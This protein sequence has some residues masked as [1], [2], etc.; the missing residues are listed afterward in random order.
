MC[1]G[2][3]IRQT[4]RCEIKTIRTGLATYAKFGNLNNIEVVKYKKM[5]NKKNEKISM[6]N[7]DTD[8]KV[9]DSELDD[10]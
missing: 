10:S 5:K 2:P 4:T 9:E 3:L 7:V 8:T 6:E 1:K